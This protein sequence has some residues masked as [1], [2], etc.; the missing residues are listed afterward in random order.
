ML[1]KE[2]SKETATKSKKH[3]NP[4]NFYNQANGISKI[5]CFSV[6]VAIKDFSE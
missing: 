4:Q 5:W 2:K 6:L 1:R 3:K